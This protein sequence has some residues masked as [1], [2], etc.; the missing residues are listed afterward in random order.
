MSLLGH[1]IRETRKGAGMSLDG[2]AAATGISKSYLWELENRETSRPSA[3]KLDAIARALGVT[4]EFLMYEQVTEPEEAH[5]DEAFFRNY[6]SLDR[7][8]K[9]RLRRILDVFKGS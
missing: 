8:E 9:E 5:L 1:K 6:K 4:L 3:E 2:L 7:S